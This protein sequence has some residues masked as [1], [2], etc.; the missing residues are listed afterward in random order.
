[1]VQSL[2]NMPKMQSPSSH[3]FS[4]SWV[5]STIT[6]LKKHKHWHRRMFIALPGIQMLPHHHRKVFLFVRSCVNGRENWKYC[7]KNFRFYVDL[8]IWNTKKN[9]IWL[10]LSIRKSNFPYIGQISLNLNELYQFLSP[11]EQ[12]VN[13]ETTSNIK[14]SLKVPPLEID[15]LGPCPTNYSFYVRMAIYMKIQDS[16][17]LCQE[18]SFQP[19]LLSV[20]HLFS[21]NSK[22]QWDTLNVFLHVLMS[23]KQ[24]LYPAN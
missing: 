19:L 13:W 15:I 16:Q 20:I 2:F 14:S 5:P 22:L 6:T 3:S 4:F 7:S 8:S 1:M 17:Y 21:V 24:Y 9:N 23:E 10:R 18:N 12:W 11:A